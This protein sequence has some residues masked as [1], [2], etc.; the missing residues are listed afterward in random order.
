MGGC[1]LLP[2]RVFLLAGKGGS[3]LPWGESSAAPPSTATG[4]VGRV[5]KMGFKKQ[6]ETAE[7]EDPAPSPSREPRPA[8]QHPAS[9][10]TC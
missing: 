3:V 2:P 1:C 7:H 9:P 6:R 5:R 4:S 8:G 10:V